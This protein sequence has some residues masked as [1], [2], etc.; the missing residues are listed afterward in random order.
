[1]TSAELLADALGRVQETVHESVEGL[2]ASQLTARL[3][4]DATVIVAACDVE[5]TVLGRE[6]LR[7]LIT[8]LH[9]LSA[10]QRDAV[11]AERATGD[12]ERKRCWPN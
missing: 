7:T 8:A 10:S 4:D 2:T 12:T 6:R 3:D 11:L 5:H 9:A 1:M